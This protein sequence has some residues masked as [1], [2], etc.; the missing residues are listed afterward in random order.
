MTLGEKAIPDNYDAYDYIDLI[1]EDKI[2]NMLIFLRL[3][4]IWG[5]VFKHFR[6]ESQRARY[7]YRNLAKKP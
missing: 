7:C 3:I 1:M 5:S 6:F 2:E 4:E